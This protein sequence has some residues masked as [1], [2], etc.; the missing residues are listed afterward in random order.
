M[1]FAL[2]E[3]TPGMDKAKY[4]NSFIQALGEDKH[5]PKNLAFYEDHLTL[6]TSK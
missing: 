2:P 4:L 6:I 1:K 5:E 3:S